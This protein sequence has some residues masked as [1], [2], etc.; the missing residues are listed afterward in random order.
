MDSSICFH[1]ATTLT[2]STSKSV[3]R[4][5]C[6]HK[7]ERSTHGTDSNTPSP[8]SPSSPTPPPFL[9]R[10][11][12]ITT[13]SSSSVPETETTT[14]NI[15]TDLHQSQHNPDQSIIILLRHGATDWNSEG[16]VQGNLDTSRL[17]ALGIHQAKIAGR[18]LQ[19]IKFDA[20][21]CSP[22]TR[23]R[24]TYTLVAKSSKNESLESTKPNFLDVLT[25]IQ[26]PWQGLLKREIGTSEYSTYFSRFK[27]QPKSFSFNGFNPVR[28]VE[29]RAQAVWQHVKLLMPKC[30]LIVA[31]NQTNKALVATALG[32]HADLRMLNQ[33]NCCVNVFALPKGGEPVLRLCNYAPP[34]VV[35]TNSEPSNNNNEQ[36]SYN[37]NNSSNTRTGNSWP[38]DTTVTEKTAVNKSTSKTQGEHVGALVYKRPMRRSGYTRILIHHMSTSTPASPSLCSRLKHEMQSTNIRNLYA[39]GDSKELIFAQGLVTQNVVRDCRAVPPPAVY[40]WAIDYEENDHYGIKHCDET[41]VYTGVL[42]LLKKLKTSHAN[43]SVG[44]ITSDGRVVTAFFAAAFDLGKLGMHRVHSDPGGITIIDISLSVRTNGRS[45]DTQCSLLECFNIPSDENDDIIIP[46]ISPL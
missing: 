6:S 41:S 42:S 2:T 19:S 44:I 28:D 15:N 10:P 18:R 5:T 25:E 20:V 30:A 40:Q 45:H 37:F 8:T 39:V 35:T 31:H 7:R 23:A 34:S 21:Y 9:K 13:T 4:P 27:H 1:V 46:F 36:Q 11:N 16:R 43:E 32:M 29:K 22:L 3:I 12:R 33:S 38:N 26:F 14:T 17:N 24:H